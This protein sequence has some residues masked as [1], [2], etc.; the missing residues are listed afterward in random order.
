MKMVEKIITHNLIVAKLKILI[1]YMN[2]VIYDKTNF[3]L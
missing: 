2:T 1:R 3:A